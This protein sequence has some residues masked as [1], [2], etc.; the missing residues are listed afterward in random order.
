MFD[1]EERGLAFPVGPVGAPPQMSRL[2]W[3]GVLP[4][5]G[6]GALP[7]LELPELEPVA[8]PVGLEVVGTTFGIEEQALS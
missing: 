6:A 5:A 4:L 3:A 1:G 8:A 2:C 7:E